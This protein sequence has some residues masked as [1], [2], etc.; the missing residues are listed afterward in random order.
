MAER[1]WRVAQV[2][3]KLG[4]VKQ[5]FLNSHGETRVG[6]NPT[7]LIFLICFLH[8]LMALFFFFG[9]ALTASIIEEAFTIISFLGTLLLLRW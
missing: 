9:S 3:I 1:L 7:P 4:L 6:S 8:S 5:I 2:V